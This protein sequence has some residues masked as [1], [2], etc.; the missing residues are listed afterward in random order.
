MPDFGKT[1]EVSPEIRKVSLQNGEVCKET[2]FVSQEDDFVCEHRREVCAERDEVY[3]ECGGVYEEGLNLCAEAREVWERRRFVS[4]EDGVVSLNCQP[5]LTSDLMSSKSKPP[6]IRLRDVEADDLALFFEHQR[7]PVAVAAAAFH[8]RDRAEFAQHWAALLAD[9]T[10]LKKTV[11]IDGQVAGHLASFMQEGKREV[12]YWLDRAFWGRG[13][14]TEAL[15]AFL[16]LEQTRPLYAGAAKHNAAS[17][18]VLQKCGFTLPRSV[19]ESSQD[20]DPSH[21]LLTLF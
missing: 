16:R 14:A 6:V 20:A 1:H 10:I 21:V 5:G 12:G 13:V 17:I 8:S 15:S 4:S 3:Q 7:D 2:H 19:D 11:V 9:E 18:R